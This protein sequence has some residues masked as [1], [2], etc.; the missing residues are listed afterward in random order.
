MLEFLL[1]AGK[2][3]NSVRYLPGVQVVGKTGKDGNDY[4]KRY[5]ICDLHLIVTWEV[6]LALSDK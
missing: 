4:D 2:F 5:L 3:L 1:T 6:G